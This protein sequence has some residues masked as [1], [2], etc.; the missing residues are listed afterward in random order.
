VVV[1]G[2]GGIDEVGVGAGGGGG[3]HG[4]ERALPVARGKVQGYDRGTPGVTFG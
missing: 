3:S 1:A 2:P 4:G